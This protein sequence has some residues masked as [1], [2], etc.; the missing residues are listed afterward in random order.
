MPDLVVK[1]TG[2]LL[3]H[4]SD[5]E[6]RFLEDQLEEESVTDEDY[7]IDRLTLEYMKEQGLS[8]HLRQLL[9]QALGDA[10]EVEILYK[11]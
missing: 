1:A 7:T 9:E 2:K 8:P 3:G 5:D 6:M 11:K 10:D 4:I